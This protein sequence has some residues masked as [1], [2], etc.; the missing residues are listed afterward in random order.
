MA[1]IHYGSW[2]QEIR[3][4][5]ARRLEEM[6]QLL[7]L[8]K[9][10][11][12]RK[13]VLIGESDVIGLTKHWANVLNGFLNLYGYERNIEHSIDMDISRFAGEQL[14]ILV[15]PQIAGEQSLIQLLEESNFQYL[16]T[17]WRGLRLYKNFPSADP[18]VSKIE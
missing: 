11:D 2:N 17:F 18:I 7:N 12:G 1:P 8:A 9:L 10:A 3:N 14:V 15:A 5:Q 6:P 13:I 16:F 4:L